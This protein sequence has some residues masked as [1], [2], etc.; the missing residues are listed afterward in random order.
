M[1]PFD[2]TVD[3]NDASFKE[4]DV[5]RQNTVEPIPEVEQEDLNYIPEIMSDRNSNT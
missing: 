3:F 1:A 2:L 5:D 4:E